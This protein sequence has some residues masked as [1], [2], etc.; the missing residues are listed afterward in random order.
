MVRSGV[1]W[2]HGCMTLQDLNIDPMNIT[3]IYVDGP[4]IDQFLQSI[5]LK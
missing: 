4:Y 5:Y 2:S 1:V 3:H